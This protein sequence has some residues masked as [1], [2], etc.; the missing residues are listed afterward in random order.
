M[1]ILRQREEENWL[2][3]KLPHALSCL[4][5]RIYDKLRLQVLAEFPLMM[6]SHAHSWSELIKTIIRRGIILLHQSVR[7]NA[8]E[9]ARLCPP[10]HALIKS[11]FIFSVIKS[12]QGL[13]MFYFSLSLLPCCMMT[14]NKLIFASVFYTVL[15]KMLP[16]R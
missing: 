5:G 10:P 12:F 8:P 6:T 11:P 9:E 4:V 2:L 13:L 15:P 7:P 14:N 1:P 16:T 3:P